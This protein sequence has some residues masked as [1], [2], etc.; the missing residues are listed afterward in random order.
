MEMTMRISVA[1]ALA[2]AAAVALP[3]G[4]NAASTKDSHAVTTK[5][6][7]KHF[8]RAPGRV[9]V[10]PGYVRAQAFSPYVHYPSYDVYV[11]GQYAGS[12]PDPRIRESIRQEYIRMQNESNFIR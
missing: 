1:A 7:T 4:A 11:N 3:A 6:K 9:R 10:A 2:L 5:H 8:V 12:D